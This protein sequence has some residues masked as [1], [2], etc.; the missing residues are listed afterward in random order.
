[1]RETMQS[2]ERMFHTRSEF[3]GI[4]PTSHTL[5]RAQEVFGQKI[6]HGAKDIFRL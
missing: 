5:K 6:D 3:L 2:E 4:Y 1:M